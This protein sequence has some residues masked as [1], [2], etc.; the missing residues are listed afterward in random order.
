MII[1]IHRIMTNHRENGLFIKNCASNIA[2]YANC[3]HGSHGNMDPITAIMHRI[4]HII[5]QTISIYYIGIKLYSSYV[6]KFSKKT[7]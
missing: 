2:M 6:V 4:I 5:Q 3:G 1:N 7:R